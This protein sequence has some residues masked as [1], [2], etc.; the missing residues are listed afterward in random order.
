MLSNG[1]ECLIPKHHWMWH[2]ASQYVAGQGILYDCLIVERLHRRVKK[3]S[4][5]ICNR[6]KFERSVLELVAAAVVRIEDEHRAAHAKRADT[7]ER[8]EAAVLE[9]LANRL[10]ALEP[11]ALTGSTVADAMEDVGGHREAMAE[12]ERL[13]QRSQAEALRL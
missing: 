11:A 9:L 10:K 12:T 2:I 7:H 4:R 6:S 1:E 5:R 3:F 13:L 8:H